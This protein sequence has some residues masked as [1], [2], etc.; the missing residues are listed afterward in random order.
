[1]S[2]ASD[3]M[4]QTQMES[5]ILDMIA[6]G[7]ADPRSVIIGCGGAG[8]AT[9]GRMGGHF[10]GVPRIAIN[11]D[12]T[13]LMLSDADRKI[14]IGKSV[15]FDGD[16]GGF[17]EVA[18]RCADLAQ[19]DIRSCLVSKDVAFII[20]GLGGGTGPGVAR[21]VAEMARGLGMVAFAICILPFSAEA[22]RRER[23]EAQVDGIRQ[24]TEG[25]IVLDNDNL[26]RFK[27]ASISEAFRIMDR[28][29]VN[30]ITDITGD[31][32][33]SYLATLANEILAYQD[34]ISAGQA[35]PMQMG[36][37]DHGVLADPQITPLAY[38]QPS[39]INLVDSGGVFQRC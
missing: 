8:I 32:S 20:C 16:S 17:P 23:A 12:M 19:D 21:S 4:T 11:T 18:M 25:C 36:A 34:E 6:S 35:G 9:V 39:D 5:A 30:A 13:G 37:G 29:V 22:A 38:A 28:T 33:R 2:L 15:T 14:R 31:M 27:D 7:M 26:L 10:K 24:A 3:D 1:M